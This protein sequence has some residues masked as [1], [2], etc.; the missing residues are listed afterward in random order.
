M[1]V[2][3]INRITLSLPVFGAAALAASLTTDAGF[4]IFHLATG[5]LV[6]LGAATLIAR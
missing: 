3:T 1:T 2:K 4:G 6:A 5:L